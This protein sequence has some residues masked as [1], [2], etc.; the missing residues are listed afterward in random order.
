MDGSG[1]ASAAWPGKPDKPSKSDLPGPPQ[2]SA[3]RVPQAGSARHSSP[4]AITR[5]RRAR[6]VQSSPFGALEVAGVKKRND[7]MD[8]NRRQMVTGVLALLRLAAP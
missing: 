3:I 7:H 1:D 4:L 5:L 6:N 8:M 2:R